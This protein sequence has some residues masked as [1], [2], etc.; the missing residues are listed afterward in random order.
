M[1]NDLGEGCDLLSI[2][3]VHG[4]AGTVGAL[5]KDGKHVFIQR[6][7]E[8]RDLSAEVVALVLTVIGKSV[9]DLPL[10]A[11]V[12]RE[13][14]ELAHEPSTEES[15]HRLLFVIR[16]TRRKLLQKLL[17]VL[18]GQHSPHVVGSNVPVAL[19]SLPGVCVRRRGGPADQDTGAYVGVG[20]NQ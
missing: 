2:G 18:W 8:V 20:K 17:V 6:G 5:G 19:R 15:G 16:D 4:S 7:K 3:D 11:Q 14:G 13:R 12:D 9:A 10:D 1:G